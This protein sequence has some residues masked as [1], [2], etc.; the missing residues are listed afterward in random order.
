MAEKE[1]DYLHFLVSSKLKMHIE[2]RLK[3]VET[4]RVCL[5]DIS[6]H[7]INMM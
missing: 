7:G 6:C 2:D 1:I 3:T 4:A 5:G